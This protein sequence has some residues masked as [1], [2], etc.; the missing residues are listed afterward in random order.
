MLRAIRLL[1]LISLCSIDI[2]F[3]WRTLVDQKYASVRRVML[4]SAQ[5]L[6]A[7]S[8]GC[9]EQTK[10]MV[11]EDLALDDL[12]RILL[13]MQSQSSG[14]GA[15]DLSDNNLHHLEK[16]MLSTDREIPTLHTLCIFLDALSRKKKEELGRFP[17][18]IR[19]RVS[20]VVE[21][22]DK[23]GV[24]VSRLLAVLRKVDF[25]S[26][27]L[28]FGAQRRLWY[29]FLQ[30]SSGDFVQNLHGLAK[31]ESDIQHLPDNLRNRFWALLSDNISFLS[32]AQI[33]IVV[34]S[35]SKVC[36][37]W[38]A[39]PLSLRRSLLH[40]LVQRKESLSAQNVANLLQGLA[41]MKASWS[42]LDDSFKERVERDLPTVQTVKGREAAYEL[43]V[44]RIIYSLGLLGATASSLPSSCLEDLLLCLAQ[45][46][47]FCSPQGF[48]NSLYALARL[49]LSSKTIP[50]LLFDQ[51]VAA[52]LNEK[53]GLLRKLDGQAISNV[54]WAL[55]TMHFQWK[56]NRD[57][58]DP[59]S[60][61][62]SSLV[63]AL[64]GRQSQ[65]TNQG[66]SNTLL[67][68]AKV[69]CLLL[70]MYSTLLI[71]IV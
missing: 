26:T 58:E 64:S 56:W 24:A 53:A 67:G 20:L 50:L 52:G 46:F 45:V 57:D 70:C 65:L 19:E 11:G 55:G 10:A 61:F 69:C 12:D 22:G 23:T 13:T 48:S 51:I 2:S 35:M 43:S 29:L 31:L 54:F 16:L 60:V 40:A 18:H 66:V 1:F 33:S 59:W 3:P 14:A 44:T 42:R 49:T 7:T 47:P 68:F 28:T 63:E 62:C 5:D 36:I 21:K 6:S 9:R 17:L 38:S 34:W 30:D 15:D 41:R 32:A 25:S 37:S 27:D 39:V 4:H 8:S 71:E